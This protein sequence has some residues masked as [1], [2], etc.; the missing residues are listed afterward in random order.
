MIPLDSIVGRPTMNRGISNFVDSVALRRETAGKA[1]VQF[2]TFEMERRAFQ[3]SPVDVVWLDE[4][5]ERDEIYGECLARLTSTKG[6]IYSTLT[7]MLGSN[8]GVRKRFRE[9][10][11]GDMAEVVMGL[12]DAKHIPESEHAAIASRY[13]LSERATRLYGA[14]LQGEGA[15]FE[16][17]EDMI[18]HNRD[19]ATF[20]PYWPY[21]W[22]LDFGRGMSAQ[23]HPFAAVL[24]AWDKDNDVIYIIEAFKMKQALLVQH[25]ERIKSHPGFG[26]P[27]AWPHDGTANDLGSGQTIAMLYKKAGLRM[28]PKWSTFPQSMGGGYSFEAGIA[29]MENRF[30]T[31]KLLVA[32]HLGEWF[33]EYRNYHRKDGLVVKIDDDLLSATRQVVMSISKAQPFQPDNQRDGYMHSIDLYGRGGTKFAIGSRP[34]AWGEN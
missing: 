27:V 4:Q 15:V 29:A 14:D 7:P 23:A 32:R 33:E 16:I 17:P 25:V 3:G 13:K 22:G 12:E 28:L 1:L 5:D 6:R 11:N 10:P 2:R 8:R 18:K 21:L 31:G 19:P 26:A 20:P 24:A 34:F 30:A 9:N